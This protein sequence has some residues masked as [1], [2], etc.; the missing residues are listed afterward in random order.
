MSS[1]VKWWSRN[2]CLAISISSMRELALKS[3]SRCQRLLK[4]MKQYLASH[5]ITAIWYEV[6]MRVNSMSGLAAVCA[7]QRERVGSNE[8]GRT[9]TRQ[10]GDRQSPERGRKYHHAQSKLNALKKLKMHTRFALTALRVSHRWNEHTK[11]SMICW[12]KRNV[13]PLTNF[14]NHKRYIPWSDNVTCFKLIINMH[15]H[16]GVC[17]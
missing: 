2:A 16:V 11:R 10:E 7:L 8:N 6:C 4:P 3:N 17:K 5:I 9:W 13:T 12:R 15:L 14:K 1:R